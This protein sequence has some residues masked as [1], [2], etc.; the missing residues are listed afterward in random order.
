MTKHMTV[1]MTA[2]NEE[3]A[4]KIANTLVAE[5]LC[6]CVNIIPRIRSIYRWEGKI[7]DEQEVMMVAKTESSLAPAIVSRVKALHSYDVPEIICLPI[8][9]GSGDYL[10]WIEDSVDIPTEAEEEG[11]L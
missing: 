6:A 11:E 10:N 7:W 5:K 1:L 2:P 8:D 4:A 9:T 3:E